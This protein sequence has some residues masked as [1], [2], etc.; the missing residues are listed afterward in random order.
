MKLEF[1]LWAQEK[2]DQLVVIQIQHMQAEIDT[3][4]G[5]A[6]HECELKTLELEKMWIEVEQL[7][8]KANVKWLKQ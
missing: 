7:Q 4:K 3:K 6:K 2:Q 1:D 5:L 8:S